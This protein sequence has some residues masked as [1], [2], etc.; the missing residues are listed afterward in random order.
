[1]AGKME[2]VGRFL[3]LFVCWYQGRVRGNP[4]LTGRNS[5]QTVK[6][7]KCSVDNI[8]SRLESLERSGWNS[9]PRAC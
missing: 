6:L 2:R 3:P 1:M 7:R 9:M 4:G 5:R 8:K